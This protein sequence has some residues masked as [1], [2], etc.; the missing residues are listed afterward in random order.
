MT[1]IKYTRQ[2]SYEKKTSHGLLGA[3]IKSERIAILL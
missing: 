1:R 3:K 2:V